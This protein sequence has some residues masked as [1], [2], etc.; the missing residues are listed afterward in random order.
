MNIWSRRLLWVAIVTV[1][2][3]FMILLLSFLFFN[4]GPTPRWQTV[5][6]SILCPSSALLPWPKDYFFTRL[7]CDALIWAGLSRII[8]ELIEFGRSRLT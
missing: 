5:V 1:T 2:H 6:L 4:F 7:I 3:L 8:F